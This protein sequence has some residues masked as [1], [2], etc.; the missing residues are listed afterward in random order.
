MVTVDY[1][2]SYRKRIHQE[3][4]VASKVLDTCFYEGLHR[5]IEKFGFTIITFVSDEPESSDHAELAF[6]VGL[7]NYGV[8]ELLFADTY[9][10]TIDEVTE[11]IHG[12][13]KNGV[14]ITSSMLMSE[15][16]N[17]PSLKLI[18]LEDGVKE[19]ITAQARYY[20]QTFQPDRTDYE[21]LF[22]GFADD[23][24]IF[25]DEKIFMPSKFVKQQFYK[26]SEN[27]GL[28]NGN[29]LVNAPVG[30]MHS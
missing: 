18:D 23:F 29:I 4:A 10:S 24:G 17:T 8:P 27:C 3:L 16:K 25:P 14:K 21:V 22:V 15:G 2:E 5:K 9:E 26:S 20:F 6:T 12:M 1:D 7:S 11:R 28:I 30:A 13:V 19:K